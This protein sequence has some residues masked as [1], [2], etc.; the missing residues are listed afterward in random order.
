MALGIA[1]LALLAVAPPVSAQGGAFFE[2]GDVADDD[3]RHRVGVEV[4]AHYRDSDAARFPVNFPFSRDQLPP[5]VEQG[6]LE[7]VEP[8]D[9]TEFSVVS[10]WWRGRFGTDDGSLRQIAT[11]VKLD[12]IDRYDR[13]PTSTDNEWD[14]DEAWIRFGPELEPGDPLP[15]S[16]LR[17]G[18][19]SGYLKLGKF[20]K[21]DRQNDRHL[22]SYGIVGTAFSRAEDVGLEAGLD[23]GRHLYVVA[24]V[25]A[26]N[27]VF[28][29][30]L[31]AL[32]GDHGTPVLDGSVLNPV[33]ELGPGIPILYDAD[34]ELDDLDFSNPEF[35]V[36][37]GGRFGGF[38][39]SVD[40]LIWYTERELAE[41]VELEGSFYGGDL[42]ILRGPLN[43]FPLAITSDTKSEFGA[44][45]WLYLGDLAVFGQFVD[46]DLAGLSRDG[47]EIEVAYTLELPYLGALF[48]R[49]VLPYLAPAIRYS[50]LDPDFAP[51]PVTPSPSF[52][53]DW[54]KLDIGLR[55]G[56]IED[57]L[58]LTVEYADNEFV[59]GGRTES[60]DE[61]LATLR[62]QWDRGF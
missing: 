15:E 50:T 36:G 56:L 43:L 61:L 4:K 38:N 30:D 26:G 45:L 20:A 31:N 14:L 10:L 57:L 6:A 48:G 7:T 24:S 12:L 17:E 2:R 29:R 34:V 28:L 60:A 42:D 59:R 25:T 39:W 5:G 52:A 18:G 27:P 41:T 13:N 8:G 44:N 32:A 3:A 22:E 47:W 62:V 16:T 49:P 33:P 53:W 11:K 46:Q 35:G 19:A 51:P 55:A 54:D 40:G 1:P 21:F 37:I 58:D 9:H 23:L